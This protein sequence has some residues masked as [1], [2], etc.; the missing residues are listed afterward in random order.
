M[1]SFGFTKVKILL[2]V[3]VVIMIAAGTLWFVCVRKIASQK[4]RNVVL[5]SIDTCRADY[6]S[7]YGYDRKTTPNIDALAS[8]G[9]LFE[10]VYSPVPLTLPAHCSM[11][12][13]NIPPYHGV[14]DNLGVMLSGTNVTLAEVLRENGYKTAAIVSAIVLDSKFGMDQGFQTYDVGFTE[15][16][17]GDPF[18]EQQGGVTTDKA[19]Q[20][21][22]SNAEDPFFLFLHYYDPHITYQPPQPFASRFADN[23]YAG[24]IAF[25]DHCIGRVIDK[26]RAL[27]L[28]DSTLLIVTSDHGEML[29]EHGEEAHGYFVYESSVRVP[30]IIKAPG[31]NVSRRIDD[32]VGLIDIMPTVLGLLG[33]DLS[34]PVRGQDLG[35]FLNGQ[36]ESSPR[37]LYTESMTPTKY[38]CNPLLAIVNWPWKY[39]Y[40]TEPELYHLQDDPAEKNNLLK[41]E[42]KR[43]GLL[44]KHVQLILDDNLRD[45]RPDSHIELDEK[46]VSQLHSLGYVGSGAEET[47]ELDKTKADPKEYISFHVRC[48]ML[49]GIRAAKEY[50]KGWE[51]CSQLLRERPDLESLYVIMAADLAVKTGRT[52]KAIAYYQ[53]HLQSHPEDYKTRNNLAT[54]L[55]QT[56]KLQKAVEQWQRILRH[57]PEYV[58]AHI[59][60]AAALNRLGRLD[61]SV[62]HWQK[63]LVLQPEHFAARIGL[64]ETYYRKGAIALAVKHWDKALQLHPDH[65]KTQNDLG[66]ILAT[67]DDPQLRNPEKALHLARQACELTGHKQPSYLDTLSA[68][69]AAT[70]QF[71]KAIQIAQ[72]AIT[73]T[74]SSGRDTSLVSD[75]QRRLTMYKNGQAYFEKFP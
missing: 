74:S 25:T 56:D 18:A 37:Y 42:S 32:A 41:T 10:K 35:P 17:E 43:G 71:N 4:I 67:I 46:T 31:L 3:A 27:K 9:A 75:I 48:S 68:A 66:W 16:F 1:K 70:G 34:L 60:L 36:A 20:W 59:N 12:T 44:E 15:A 22:D 30:L 54:V 45:D 47:F 21:L 51:V 53:H 2:A 73:L 13:G 63:A 11:L 23:L 49:E 62:T 61:E 39:I 6:L 26:L 55:G 64:A 29:G 52:D 72:K 69:Y 40:T 8:T 33:I 28:Y 14:H 65:A 58:K 19:C 57:E 5:I 24:E 50:E 7:C 38:N